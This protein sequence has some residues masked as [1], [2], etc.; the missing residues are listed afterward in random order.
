MYRVVLVALLFCGISPAFAA[1]LVTGTVTRI[2]IDSGGQGMIFF[3]ANVSGVAVNCA[4]TYYPNALAFDSATPGGKNLLAAALAAK[5]TGDLL[6]AYGT[7][8]C[9][10]YGTGVVEDVHYVNVL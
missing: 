10:I 5:A 2:R 4:S 3:S 9:T 7:G 8:Q 1:G 6:E